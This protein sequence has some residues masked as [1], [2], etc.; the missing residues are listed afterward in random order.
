MMNSHG[1]GNKR[2]PHEESCRVP[3][4][5]TGPGVP[6]GQVRE[7]L[8]GTIEIFPTLCSL[9]GIPIPDFCD[10]QDFSANCRGLP[11]ACD[12]DT[13]LLMHVASAREVSQK[14]GKA[15]SRDDLIRYHTPFYRGVRGKQYTYAV[16]CSGEW[17]LWDHVNDPMQMNN[18]VKNPAYE[19][20]RRAMR[21][22]LDVWLAKAEDP[23]LNEAYLKMD[24]PDRILQQAADGSAPLPLHHIVMRLKLTPEQFAQLPEIQSRLYD[25]RGFP[26][27]GSNWKS[28]AQG[29]VALI[30]NLLD[31][32]QSLLFDQMVSREL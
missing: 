11:G 1:L 13:Q 22:E 17:V 10:G 4:L 28:A 27:A 20:V 2:Y 19:E 26:Q 5:V 7:E 29:A 12:P 3:F 9:A 25:S 14:G 18:L 32:E 16:G 15:L 24:L 23:F 31:P 30:R 21:R 6:A 8:F